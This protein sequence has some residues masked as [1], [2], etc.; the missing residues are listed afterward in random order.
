MDR[1]YRSDMHKN[2][3]FVF[4]VILQEKYLQILKLN[5]TGAV[6][7]FCLDFNL[8]LI[9]QF[10]A[11]TAQSTFCEIIQSRPLKQILFLQETKTF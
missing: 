6:F 4:S 5:D 1:R 2:Y 8:E 10:L 3:C 9:L 7:G 11:N